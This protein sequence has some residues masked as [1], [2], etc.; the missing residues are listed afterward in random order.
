MTA[1][2]WYFFRAFGFGSQPP[3]SSAP[4]AVVRLPARANAAGLP[5]RANAAVL[6][7]RGAD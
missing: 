5:A 1:I 6:P 3:T 2:L 4:V 7:P